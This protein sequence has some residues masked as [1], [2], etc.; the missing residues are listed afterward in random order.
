M[1]LDSNETRTTYQSLKA[2]GGGAASVAGISR[3]IPIPPTQLASAIGAA[4]GG[5]LIGF[6]QMI[7]DEHNGNGVRLRFT[8]LGYAAVPT[9]VFPK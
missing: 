4:I 8:G 3:F 2:G 5:G 7:Q 6:G 1:F 9:G